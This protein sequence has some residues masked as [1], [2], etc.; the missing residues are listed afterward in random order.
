M[1]EIGYDKHVIKITNNGG[2]PSE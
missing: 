2:I 1:D